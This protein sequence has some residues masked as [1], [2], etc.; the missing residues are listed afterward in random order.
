MIKHLHDNNVP[1]TKSIIQYCDVC[2]TRACVVS[3]RVHMF[4][5]LAEIIYFSGN[6]RVEVFP[7]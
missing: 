4:E 1:I 2:S 7:R 6:K 3:K 5:S